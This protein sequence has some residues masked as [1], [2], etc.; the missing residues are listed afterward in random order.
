[1]Q[2]HDLTAIFLAKSCRDRGLAWRCRGSVKPR[3]AS[4]IVL[5]PNPLK[6]S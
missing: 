6:F 4:C 5:N 1:M 2:E 3:K